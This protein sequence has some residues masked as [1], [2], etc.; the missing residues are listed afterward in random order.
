MGQFHNLRF[1]VAVV[2][3]VVLAA[4]FSTPSW[5]FDLPAQDAGNGFRSTSPI[6]ETGNQLSPIG[7]INSDGF[8]DFAIANPYYDVTGATGQDD[9]GRVYVLFGSANMPKDSDLES[10]VL[11]HGFVVTGSDKNWLGYSISG[12]C[13]VNGDNISDLLIGAPNANVR[14]R[15]NVPDV[16]LAGKVYV[17]LGHSADTPFNSYINVD[18]PATST[19]YFN[20]VLYG[21]ETKDGLGLSVSCLKDVNNDGID[22][23]LAGSAISSAITSNNTRRGRAYLIF[24]STQFSTNASDP[25]NRLVVDMRDIYP[26][27]ATPSSL[28][29]YI[30]AAQF[31]ES[32]DSFSQ[33][34]ASLGDVNGDNINDF[35][36]SAPTASPPGSFSNGVFSGGVFR[37]GQVYVLFGNSNLSNIDISEVIQGNSPGVVLNGE[38]SQDNLGT[39]LYWAGDINQ[40]GVNEIMLGSPDAAVDG[41]SD[42]G[43]A[44]V[45]FG[46]SGL[47]GNVDLTALANPGAGGSA[48]DG[49]IVDG[50]GG[51]TGANVLGLGDVNGDSIDDFAI[52]AHTLRSSSIAAGGGGGFVIYGRDPQNP[53]P[54]LFSV[55]G[56]GEYNNGFGFVIYG[57]KTN[58]NAGEKMAALGDFNGDG[59]ADFSLASIKHISVDPLALPSKIYVIYGA[60]NLETVEHRETNHAGAAVTNTPLADDTLPQHGVGHAFSLTLI[61]SLWLL[62]GFMRNSGRFRKFR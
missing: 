29:I 46:R 55:A 15:A 34:V 11:N 7:D 23:I 22:D 19:N 37:S 14:E 1:V 35:A 33:A 41:V 8:N 47:N 27:S 38:A 2:L 44:Y 50:V 25:A 21:D 54:S 6:T 59:L 52:S 10:W 26:A 4:L 39:S 61:L 18:S 53:F 17:I 28:G 62:M 9:S 31:A 60:P 16:T 49:F 51:R 43:R 36:I 5:A 13:D 58:E 3:A 48:G 12:N 30:Q 42:Q 32:P 56:L 45:I 24:G 40:D 20:A 57:D